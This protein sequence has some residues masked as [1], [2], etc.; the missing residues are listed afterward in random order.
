MFP[1]VPAGG[2]YHHHI[3]LPPPLPPGLPPPGARARWNLGPTPPHPTASVPTPN[4]PAGMDIQNC[5]ANLNGRRTHLVHMGVVAVCLAGCIFLL[6]STC[7]S[8]RL[9]TCLLPPSLAKRDG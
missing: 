9:P 4:R 3:C 7:A 6:S 2:A 8:H 1:G 5:F